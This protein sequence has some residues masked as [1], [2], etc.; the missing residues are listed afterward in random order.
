M[1]PPEFVV[2]TSPHVH[3]GNSV[4]RMML[5][6][7]VALL[8]AVAAA[9][10]V[11]GVDSLKV[12]AISMISAVFWDAA[13]QKL[14]GRDLSIDDLSAAAGGLVL[15]MLLPVTVPWWVI[16]LGTL[17][18]LLLGKH[19]YGG[20]GG[21]PFNGVIIAY[22]VL[23][24]SYPEHM[25][26]LPVPTSDRMMTQ[27]SPLVELKENGASYL[28]ESFPWQDLFLGSTLITG[29]IGE[30]SKLALL[31]GGVFL[32]LR[33]K[34]SWIIPVSYLAG[35]AGIATLFWLMD[36]DTWASPLFHLL[37][38]GSLLTAFF[39]ATDWTTSPVTKYGMALFGL[40]CGVM[41]VAI[42]LWS[43]WPEGAYFSVFMISMLTPVFDKI[44]P[45]VFGSKFKKERTVTP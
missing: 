40:A 30:I 34:I 4:R 5:H 26:N 20:L 25:G 3:S 38:G 1:K 19:V 32:L 33:K 10:L 18:M 44:R 31:V 29:A 22:V 16:V 39:I 17:V 43:Q 11:F 28:E 21:N 7:I 41:T 24:L 37:A 42:R 14:F 2:S 23:L 13:L 9:Y 12:V 15:A 27:N 8:P 36:P 6:L 45:R 35:L